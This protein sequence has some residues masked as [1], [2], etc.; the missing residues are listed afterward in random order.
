MV[1]NRPGPNLP[2][3]IQVAML[4][5]IGATRGTNASPLTVIQQQWKDV[6]PVE[7]SDNE[8]LKQWQKDWEA[9]S[10]RTVAKIVYDRDA[11]VI[12]VTVRSAGRLLVE[13]SFEVKAE[14]DLPSVL[15]SVK[16]LIKEQAR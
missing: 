13:R 4:D 7:F 6:K 11:G 8:Q 3:V 12:R 10:N 9:G 16:S 14:Q 5:S 1:L 15:E 2:P